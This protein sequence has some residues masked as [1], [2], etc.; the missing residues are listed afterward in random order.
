MSNPEHG[1]RLPAAAKSLPVAV[2][3]AVVFASLFW[4]Y[5]GWS[6]GILWAIYLRSTSWIATET[7]L[8][9]LWLC[10][11]PKN[12]IIEE[13]TRKSEDLFGKVQAAK[14][15]RKRKESER[16]EA[17][18][19]ARR[20][21]GQQE[22]PSSSATSHYRSMGETGEYRAPPNGR[23]GDEEMGVKVHHY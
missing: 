10:I 19:T 21:V 12:E 18:E 7:G 8:Y 2:S 11:K 4:A 14:S 3:A 5:S 15:D 17:K 23:L 22:T 1:H 13:A 6:R 16:K 20:W 9:R